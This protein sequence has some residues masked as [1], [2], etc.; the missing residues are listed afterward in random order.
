MASVS[1]ET[2]RSNP[3]GCYKLL[4]T[5]TEPKQEDKQSKTLPEDNNAHRHLQQIRYTHRTLGT[6]RKH[7]SL[8]D[9]V[10]AS[11]KPPT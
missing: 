1:P 5:I 10:L 9:T 8:D 2:T 6:N 3:D 7:S 11:S 4:S